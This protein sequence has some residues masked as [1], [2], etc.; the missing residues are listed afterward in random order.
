MPSDSIPPMQNW[1]MEQ[2]NARYLQMSKEMEEVL[3]D[4]ENVVP[5]P[6]ELLD[7]AQRSRIGMWSLRLRK[8]AWEMGNV[9]EEWRRRDS[10]RPK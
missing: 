5:A 3:H 1:T 2:L 9:A 7:P 8:I 6:D 10:E 4:R